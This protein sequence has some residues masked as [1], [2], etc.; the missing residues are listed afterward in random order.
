MIKKIVVAPDSFKGTM[1]SIEICNIIEESINSIRSDIN[2]VKLPI[3]DGGEGTVDAFLES[4]GGTKIGVM[5]KDPYM[6]EIE[7]HYCILS[8][9]KTAVIEMAA[10]SGLPL[11]GDRLDPRETT[12]YGTGQLMKDALDRGCNKIIV[13]IG[14]SATNDGGIGMAAALGVSFLD[15]T[16]KEVSLNGKGLADID[17][18]DIDGRDAR[19]NTCEILVACDVDNPLYGVNGAAYIFAPQKGADQAIVEYLDD[20]LKH[21][22]EILLRD[23]KINAQEIPGS[24]AAGGLG[25][26]LVTFAGAKLDSGIKIVLDT[27]NF[28][29]IIKDAQLVIT[30]EG[31]IDGQSLRGKASVG[32]AQ[33]AQENDVPVIAIVGDIGDDYSSVYQKGINAVFS[34]NRKAIPFE[35]AKHRSK[36]D[37]RTTMGDIIRLISSLDL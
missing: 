35:I 25:A 27:V 12:T 29:E 10:A 7:A 34:I 30:G 23:F 14:G 16:G 19:L 32:V 18:I 21:Y 5:V 17:S 4:M 28:G 33:R 9:G 24:G 8:D 6:Q 37:L 31:K 3:A 22:A 1:S 2:I 13:G 20:N 11:V 36:E 15:K 26:G